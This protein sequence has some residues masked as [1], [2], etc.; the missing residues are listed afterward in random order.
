MASII[1]SNLT[2]GAVAFSAPGIS[3]LGPKL[4][5]P[6]D[7]GRNTTVII[8]ENDQVPFIDL[9]TGNEIRIACSASYVECHSMQRTLCELTA[10]CG[11]EIGSDTRLKQLQ[12]LCATP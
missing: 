11:V 10:R 7:A 2:I 3:M 1:A 4:S 5:L 9:H 12:T 8:P 6:P